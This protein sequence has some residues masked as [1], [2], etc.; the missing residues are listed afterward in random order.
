MKNTL[1]NLK[2]KSRSTSFKAAALSVGFHALLVL[3][4][5]S[6]VAVHYIQ[7]QNAEFTVT[8]GSPKPE[9][10]QTPAAKPEQS[11]ET[12]RPTKIVSRSVSVS[13]PA[14]TAP[15]VVAPDNKPKHASSQKFS[16]PAA[17]AGRGFDGIARQLG[18]GL[19]QIDFFG[20]RA[21]GEKFVFIIDASPGMLAKETGGLPT[22]SYIKDRVRKTIVELP[23]VVLYNVILYDGQKIFQFRPQMV[24]ATKANSAAFGAWIQ[25]VN[26]NGNHAGLAEE[27]NN[28]RRAESYQTAVG[29]DATCWLLALQS[30]FE[31]RP[32]NVFILS[33]EWGKHNI[34]PEKRRLLRDFSLWELLNSGGASSVGGSPVLRDDR[35]LRDNLIKQAVTTIQKETDLR[36]AAG[37][38]AEFLH[39]IPAYIEYPADQI[40]DHAEVV[41]R[42]QYMPQQ[43]ARPQVH[44]VRLLSGDSY[45]RADDSTTHM[46]ELVRRYSGEF[47][48]LSGEQAAGEQQAVFASSSGISPVANDKDSAPKKPVVP[49]SAI[50]FLGA[51]ANGSKV[52]FI[53]DAS[54]D[55][56]AR[57]TGGTNTYALI[58]NQLVKTVEAL[59]PDALFN[60]IVYDRK[61]VLLFR[62]QMVPAAQSGGLSLWL[63]DLNSNAA[64]SGLRPEQNN[65]APSRVY[66]TAIG[67]DVQSLPYALQA[68]ME[69]QPGTIFI[70]STGMG[71]QPVNPEK[72]G[73]LLDFSIWSAL[74]GSSGTAGSENMDEEGNITAT[75]G[76]ASTAG[77]L[78]QPLQ[79]DRKMA[80]ALLKQTLERIATE[81]KAR[82][83]AGLPSGFVPDILNSIQY[84]RDQVLAHI[85]TVCSE[86]YTSQDLN[87]PEIHF[88]C[89]QGAGK[90]PVRETLRDL[91]GLTQAYGGTVQFLEGAPVAQ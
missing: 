55:M 91:R 76:T 89:L 21:E 41:Y 78:L 84:P 80:D 16:F 48:F 81:K 22:Y 39:E 87:A 67:S 53:L 32:D 59:S 85:A 52:I 54:A 28:Y 51:S 86:N 88:I 68:A 33:D 31:Q 69:E 72:A 1:A 13:A 8:T 34:N 11:R 79:Q 6:I 65:Y 15:T 25:P 29:I 2:S 7:K 82:Q 70:A 56:L 63:A 19:P 49:G 77:S 57:K 38:S 35:K 61:Q 74:G 58:K 23:S 50:Q 42:A 5:G 62:S 4:A 3:F 14:F 17:Q 60:V 83:E 37:L 40:L 10:R 26:T 20:I 24:P 27:Q 90:S 47:E 44:V 71:S 43:F 30:A 9:R 36:K 64:R 75:S 12:L 66:E 46:R 45:G 73:R 18:A